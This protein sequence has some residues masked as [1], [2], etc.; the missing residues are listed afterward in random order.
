[1]I[2]ALPTSLASLGTTDPLFPGCSHTCH[3]SVIRAGR[4]PPTPGTLLILFSALSSLPPPVDIGNS[5]NLHPLQTSPVQEGPPRTPRLSLPLALYSQ[6]HCNFL[7]IALCRIGNQLSSGKLSVPWD[8]SHECFGS[9]LSLTCARK[10]V[11][12]CQMN[13]Q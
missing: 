3:L 1:M 10:S 12:I 9:I 5:S 11:N 8:R 6:S 4:P 2:W 7:R 13:E